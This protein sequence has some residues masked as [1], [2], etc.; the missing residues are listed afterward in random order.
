MFKCDHTKLRLS[1]NEF[2]DV[3]ASDMP[4][5]GEFCLLELKDGRYT[6]G[7]WHPKDYENKKSVSGKF[8]RGTADT[9]ASS[10]V[11]KWHSL[12]RYDLTSCL[13]D[14]EINYINLGPEGDEIHTVKFKD[15]KSFKDGDF[16]K[17]E[18]YCL[19]I[20]KNGGL[21]SGRWDRL[22][23]KEGTFIYAPALACHSMNEVWAWTPLS[24]D[25]IFDR[26]EKEEK[27]RKAEE[28]LNRDP[29]VDPELFR[30]GTD[31]GVYYEKALE[32][33][34]VKYPWASLPQM[35][36]KTPYIITPR[37][38]KYIFGKDNGTFMGSKIVDEWKGGKTADEFI[39]FLCEYTAES[40][41]DS[42]P[43]VKFRLGTDVTVYLEKAYENVKKDYRW[44]NKKIV[45]GSWRYAIKQV[46]GDPEFVRWSDNEKDF[47]VLDCGSA[48]NFIE[49]VEHDYQ[50]A[51]LRA[52]PVTAQ[53]S[54]PFGNVDLH[55]WYLEKYVFSKLKTGD[56]KVYV[57]AGDRVTGGSR[58]FF[59][60]PYCFEAKTYEEFLDRYLQIV[61]GG[62][63][64]IFKEDLLNDVK[65]KKFLGYN[66]QTPDFAPGPKAKK[67]SRNVTGS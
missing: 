32:K 7:E 55:G 18:Q 15:F 29:S 58:E 8:I 12:E 42:D 25:E 28:E 4:D 20:L 37:H 6:A 10:E 34:R 27:E 53:Y 39:D 67:S 44:L 66:S 1:F 3:K 19:L 9:V 65:L 21:A 11:S 35:K 54:V 13:E 5:Y 23:E 17:S 64:G 60:T 52:N 49:N 51:A 41:Q 30:Y 31:I 50:T 43:A 56:Y 14:E 22:D 24:S 40:V 48:E 46:D 2:H 47:T 36:K 38:G 16:P 59:I 57:Q 45:G 26:E 33:L 61:P 63:F 62:S